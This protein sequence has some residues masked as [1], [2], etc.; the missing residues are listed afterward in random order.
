MASI[1]E[2]LTAESMR[3][4]ES[5]ALRSRY[6][7]EGSQSG[8][9][10]S[11]L[12]GQ[13][14][15]FADRREYVKGDNLRHLDWK[16]FART[17]KYYIRQFEAETSLRVHLLIDASASMGFQYSGRF[18]KYEYAAR[19]AASL[20]YL[21]TKQQDSVGLTI[22]D[23]QVRDRLPCKNGA[24]HLRLI[25]DRLA[26]NSAQDG[27]DTGLALHS[28]AEQLSRRGLII[29]MS[30]CFD[31]PEGIFSAI[32][33]FRKR[34]N[35]V[36]LLQIV[37]PVELDLSL[38]SIAQFVD[39]ETGE[40]LELDP[41]HARAAYKAEM[42]GFVDGIRERCGV[43]NVDYRLASTAEAFDSFIQQ[44]LLDRKKMAL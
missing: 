43:M 2:F 19:L 39:M 24:R 4:L 31:D 35:D 17:E 30:D 26:A 33:H 5:L 20:A 27:T 22:Y 11:P 1:S 9:H 41:A 7:S 29:I 36:V 3:K 40:K 23:K 8:G 18:S 10:K 13:S 25:L 38:S 14:V 44:Y 37:D 12:K 15:E 28:M 32:A 16:V 6:V 42:Q 34:M 21:V